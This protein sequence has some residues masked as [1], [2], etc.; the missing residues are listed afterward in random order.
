MVIIFT[1]LDYCNSLL[2]SLPTLGLESIPSSEDKAIHL[3]VNLDHLTSVFKTF[4]YLPSLLRVKS[5]SSQWFTKPYA[6]WFLTS[7]TSSTT[8][9]P[10][11]LHSLYSS[12]IGLS[13]DSYT[14]QMFSY[15]RGPAF[16]ISSDWI[17]FP[18]QLLITCSLPSCMCSINK[19]SRVHSPD[20]D[21]SNSNPIP[22]LTL[23]LQFLVYFSP[24]H[25]LSSNDQLYSDFFIDHLPSTRIYA[26][27]K[28]AFF[29]TT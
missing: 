1:Y 14:G 3:K 12:H 22:I 10:L 23:C 13:V 26:P 25:S 4:Q 8:S 19:F 17:V 5:E 27:W 28:Q 21:I 29:S 24:L 20:P 9:F 16:A 11:P 2:V 6:I 15:F 18:R 7:L